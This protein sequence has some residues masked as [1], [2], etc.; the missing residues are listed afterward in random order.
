M[1]ASY[2]YILASQ[3]N[4][5]LYI[6]VTANLARR[7]YEHKNSFIDGFASKYKIALLVYY[8]EFQS[9][10]DAIKR[11]KQLKKW[12]R[13]WK[14]ELINKVNPQWKDLYFE[15]LAEEDCI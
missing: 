9:I 8:E 13:A 5:T 2:V 1:P 7:I 10:D 3:F 6:G 4:G 11:E 14:L 12:N 15:D